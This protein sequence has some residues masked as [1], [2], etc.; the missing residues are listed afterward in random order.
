M[1]FVIVMIGG[2]S[3][4]DCCCV[5]VQCCVCTVLC[6]CR[7][8]YSHTYLSRPMC[9]H[10]H[11][12]NQ[13]T[14]HNHPTQTS[15][16]YIRGEGTCRAWKE[17]QTYPCHCSTAG[18]WCWYTQYICVVGMPS[19]YVLIHKVHVQLVWYTVHF[20][21]GTQ[22]WWW[23]YGLWCTIIQCATHACTHTRHKVD[24]NNNYNIHPHIHLLPQELGPRFTLKL[25]SLQRGTFDSKE[26]EFEWVN[27][28]GE[29][30]SRRKFKL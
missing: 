22:W 28:S 17:N 21:C 12:H 3:T 7:A 11:T 5:C 23:V 30:R 8:Q 16:L 24:I 13:H 6:M 9:A 1:I 2:S 15:S 4:G 26:G 19:K 18:M 25:I 20:W 27:K 10:A 14:H 29:K